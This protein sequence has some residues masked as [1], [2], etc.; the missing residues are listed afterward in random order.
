MTFASEASA[1]RDEWRSLAASLRS[2]GEAGGVGD[3]AAFVERAVRL[4]QAFAAAALLEQQAH[5]TE[6]DLRAEIAELRRERDEQDR[7]LAAHRERLVRW[8]AECDGV[9]AECEGADRGDC[10]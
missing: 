1:L 2:A 5:E 6:D 9:Q 10:L 8:Q 3:V 4:Q 7:L